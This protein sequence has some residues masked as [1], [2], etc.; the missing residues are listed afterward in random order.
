[1]ARS[2]EELGVELRLGSPVKDMGDGYVECGNA[3]IF[4]H[5]T[6]WA[7][8]VKASP[9]A[10]WLRSER[11]GSGRVF[12]DHELRVFGTPNIFAIGDTAN[13]LGQN[14]HALPAIAPV[15]KQQGRYV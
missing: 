11:D 4:A 3:L 15:A 10:E 7:A 6:V 13:A 5:T 8:G 14:G 2:L 1:A 12:V 9:A